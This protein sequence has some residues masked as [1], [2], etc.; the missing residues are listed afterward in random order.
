MGK[1]V[2]EVRRLTANMLTRRKRNIAVHCRLV[3]RFQQPNP[4]SRTPSFMKQKYDAF[5]DNLNDYKIR[6]EKQQEVIEGFMR[7][8][9]GWTD[10]QD[11]EQDLFE[12]WYRFK[13]VYE[14]VPPEDDDIIR[15][16]RVRQMSANH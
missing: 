4:W 1:T 14:I 15:Q 10:E 8:K 9:F 5:M 12:V 3:E 13:K 16:M 2:Q 6:M 11:I 7:Q